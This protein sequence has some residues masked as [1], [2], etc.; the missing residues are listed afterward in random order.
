MHTEWCYSIVQPGPPTTA[1]PVLNQ[2]ELHHN[3][4][5]PRVSLP[6]PGSWA[7]W[8]MIGLNLA[9]HVPA[10]VFPRGT[11]RLVGEFSSSLTRSAPS[12]KT[13]TC[14]QVQHP[15]LTWSARSPGSCMHGWVLQPGPTC[16]F[17]SP[18]LNKCQVGP[19]QVSVM[20]QPGLACHHPSSPCKLVGAVISQS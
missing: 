3:N 18:N 20:V 8:Q 5:V 1:A 15:C 16:P 17:P 13:H 11:C 12:S 6:S 14:Q 7:C 9:W 19:C 4:G 10:S 2:W